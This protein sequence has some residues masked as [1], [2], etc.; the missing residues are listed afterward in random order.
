MAN[1]TP[2]SPSLS[3]QAVPSPGT[4]DGD[5]P[6]ETFYTPIYVIT[7]VFGAIFIFGPL[8]VRKGEN[9]E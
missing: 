9:K 2:P 8:L 1:V 4:D 7:A 5:K 6:V 3:P